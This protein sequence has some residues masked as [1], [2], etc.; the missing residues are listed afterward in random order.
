MYYIVRKAEDK[1]TADRA[2][3]LLR[4]VFG[5]V[6]PD[7]WVINQAIDSDCSDF[8]DAVQFHSANRVRAQ[9]LVSRNPGDFPHSKLAITTPEE[10]LA[11]WA[12]R[13]T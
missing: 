3:R 8:E 6:A 13:R 5:S 11:V 1:A 9:F 2:L 4:D 12:E 7:D 10:F